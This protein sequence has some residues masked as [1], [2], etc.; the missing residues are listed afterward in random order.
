M[1]IIYPINVL[2]KPASGNCNLRCEYCFYTDIMDNRAIKNYGIMP[3][4]TLENIVKKTLEQAHYSCTFAFQGGEPT[5]TGLEFYEHLIK[6]Q[7]KYNK[8]GLLINNAIQTNG[9]NLDESWAKFLAQN[10]FLVGLSLDGDESINDKLRVD[11][12]KQGTFYRVMTAAKLLN[13]YSVEYNILTVVTADVAKNIDEIYRFFRKNE[14]RYLQFIPCLDPLYTEHG[15][16]NFSLTP[17]LFGKFLV[18]L[19]DSWYSDV[20]NKE[21]IYI[22]YFE[23]LLQI[24]LGYYPEACGMLGRCSNQYVIESDGSVYPC[25]F[26]V[27][28]DYK[29]GNLNFESFDDI[30]NRRKEVNFIGSSYTNE[31]SCRECKWHKLCFGGCRREREAHQGVGLSRNYLCEGYKIFFEYAYDKI[32]EIAVNINRKN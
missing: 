7:R 2:I 12:K 3:I 28:D 21:F 29:I 18:T 19:F 22:R 31:S 4:D 1:R 15:T 14:F 20:K 8:K 9:I 6:F 26:Y 17:E 16:Y 11:T 32:Y 23:N 5:L 30:D 27:L 24:M 13:K 10:K 25:D